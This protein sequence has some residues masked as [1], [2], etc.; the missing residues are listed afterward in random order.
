MRLRSGTALSAA[1]LL[2][3]LALAGCGGGGA[4]STASSSTAQAPKSAGQGQKSAAKQDQW[5]PATRGELSAQDKSGSSKQSA[6]RERIPPI[7]SAPV[8]GSTTPAPGV[9]TVKGGDN[10]V[11]AYGA[12]S[13]ESAR[14]EA[15]IVL[16]AYLNAR[17]QEDWQ[18][19]CSYLAQR[20]RAEL[21]ELAEK[22]QAQGKE[23]DGCAG[24]MGF[25]SEGVPQSALGESAAIEKALSFR[26]GGDQGE[27]GFLLYVGEP[28]STLY[29]VPMSPEGG[30]WK[31]ATVVP[32]AL[33]V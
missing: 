22:A 30:G 12:E 33:P 27:L 28:E 15:A 20:V 18:G 25:L 1:A 10:S 8:A 5:K 17:L 11:Q 31:V 2:A 7:S 24:A 32:N 21:Q 9:K 16:Q 4:E 19:A 13:S 14:V 6:P 23:I 26:V 29:S 3:A